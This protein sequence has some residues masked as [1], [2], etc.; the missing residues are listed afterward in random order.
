MFRILKPGGV[1][2]I[3]SPLNFRIHGYPDDYW[4]MTPNCLR[5]LLAPTPRGSRAFRVTTL[6][7]IRSWGSAS[8]PRFTDAT[9]TTREVAAAYNVWLEKI[10]ASLPYRREVRRR[11]SQ[12]Y[13]SKGERRQIASYYAAEFAIDVARGGSAGPATRIR[14]PSDGRI[15]NQSN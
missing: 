3:T 2:V 13:R 14:R 10:E 1:F 7:R 9:A 6:F 8:R 11:V 4:R 5:R 12:I 15:L